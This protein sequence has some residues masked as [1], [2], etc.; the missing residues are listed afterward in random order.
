MKRPPPIL[1]SIFWFLVVAVPLHG[2]LVIQM[3]TIGNPGNPP[4]VNWWGSPGSVPYTYQ[5][6]TY[7]VTVAQYTEFLNSV[8]QSD[9]NG[10]Y[11]GSMQ[12]GP[13]GAFIIQSGTDGSYTYAAVPGTENQPVR[14]VSFY[15]AARFC[16]WLANGQGSSSTE[17]GV[18]DMAQGA[19]V[20][21]STN[22]TWVVPSEDEWY[23]AAYYDPV[24]EVYN[25]YPNGSSAVPAE[26]TDGTTQREM[27]FGGLP[28]W[29]PD[30]QL[31]RE[32]YTATGETSAQSPYGVRDMGGNVEEWTDTQGELLARI[33]RGGHYDASEASLRTTHQDPADPTTDGDFFGFRVAFIIPEPSVLVLL[34]MGASFLWLRRKSVRG[35]VRCRTLSDFAAP[36]E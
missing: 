34:S 14:W 29:N 21:R 11:V 6:S 19:S 30:G 4:D 31:P 17:T 12:S 32:W 7:E 1:S 16:N 27:N 24:N 2:D 13:N 23:K 33:I 22:A 5:I 3:T 18:Y 10:L 8:A 36:E 25:T 15:D 9:P 28:Y 35:G 26:P 20:T